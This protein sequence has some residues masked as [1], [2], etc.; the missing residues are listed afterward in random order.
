MGR[1]RE[2]LIGVGYDEGMDVFDPV[3]K[4]PQLY[5]ETAVLLDDLLTRLVHQA[6]PRAEAVA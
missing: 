1:R 6:W 3:G 2:D 4:G 5:E